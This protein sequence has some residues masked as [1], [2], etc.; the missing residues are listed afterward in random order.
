MGRIVLYAI[1]LG[2]VAVMFSSCNGSKKSS[3]I[4]QIEKHAKKNPID[5]NGNPVAPRGSESKKVRQAMEKQQKQQ[6]T[7]V[8]EVE[9]A[10]KDALTRHRA[11][12]TQETRNRMDQHLKETEKRH[13]TKKEF[14]L[15]RWFKPGDNIEKVE[16]RRAKE[17]Q[18]RMAA[19]RKQAEKN[20]AAYRISSVKTKERKAKKLPDPKDVVHGGGGTY[21]E[22]NAAKR[23]NPSDFQHGG[24]GSYQEGK[25]GK[26][27]KPSSTTV[28]PQKNTLFKK[29]FSRKRKSGKSK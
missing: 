14:F 2:M 7:T 6:A 29:L 13:R 23:V 5:E 1:C 8:K 24:G 26:N 4:R 9:K 15:V 22:G 18:K 10:H 27:I 25:S 28:E 12:Q 19:T 16:K 11:F 3:S 17:V 21:K 20:N